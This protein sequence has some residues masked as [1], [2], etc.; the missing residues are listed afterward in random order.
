MKQQADDPRQKFVVEGGTKVAEFLTSIAPVC[1]IEGPL[2][3][4][5]TKALCAKPMI[6]AQQQA[7]SP[8]DGIRRTRFA[9]VRNTTPDLKRTTIRSWLELYPE[10]VYGKLRLGAPMGHDIRFGDVWMQV[11]FIGLDKDDDVRKLRSG[12]YTAIF[13]DEIEFIEKSLFDEARS[14]LR[15]PPEEH[16]GPTQR[17]VYAATNAPPEDHWLPIMTGRVEFPTGLSQDEIAALKWPSSWDHLM[18][19]PALIEE[20]DQHGTVIGYRVNPK[21]E[22]LRNL[23]VKGNGDYYREQLVGQ[24]KAWIDSRLMVRTVLVSD[25][26]PVWPTF[27]REVFV[28]REILH[29]RLGYPVWVGTDYGRSPAAVFIQ[30]I[31]NRVAVQHEMIGTAES[32]DTF[33]PRV[34]RFLTQNYPDCPVHAFGD[35]KGN[36]HMQNTD[37]TSV[38]IFRAHGIEVRNPPG[39]K[40][41]DIGTRVMAVS[42]LLHQMSDAAVPRFVVSPNCRTLIVAMA[43]RYCNTRDDKGELNPDK[44]RYSHVSDALQYVVLGL[45]EGRAM[46]GL[47]P[48]GELRG[49]QTWKKRKTMRRLEA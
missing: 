11:D 8:V 48:I 13:F 35:P 23:P 1:I 46:I 28:S 21:A 25:G 3:S 47:K 10:H 15:F 37:R 34:A 29:P 36:D 42:H 24:T 12:E 31:N 26:S 7:P 14:R 44:N 27:R 30:Q 16:G 32:T 38:E 2:G 33:A 41:N 17:G 22:N 4:G 6:L 9:M 45:G 49:V 5:K 43:G 18:Q 39:L 19:P 40:K 20:F